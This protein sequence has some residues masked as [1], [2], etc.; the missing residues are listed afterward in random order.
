MAPLGRSLTSNEFNS[1][2]RDYEAWALNAR[3]SYADARF[4]NVEL[5]DVSIFAYPGQEIVVATFD[6]SYESNNVSQKS[7]KRQYWKRD[8][9][10]RWK[11]IYEGP[12]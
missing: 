2:G 7:K 3:V 4:I 12:V 6:Q 5:S 9:L 8:E 11:I 10:Q 1:G